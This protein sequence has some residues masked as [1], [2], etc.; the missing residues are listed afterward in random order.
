MRSHGGKKEKRIRREVIARDGLVCCYCDKKLLLQ[1]VT[2]EHIVPHSKKGQFNL[3]N[4][5]VSCAPCNNNRSSLDFFLYAKR[6]NWNKKKTLKYKRLYINGLKVKVLNLAKENFLITENAVPNDLIF[7]ACQLLKIKSIDLT[8]Y[9][10]CLSINFNEMNRR[11]AIIFNF[12][13]LIKIIAYDN[14]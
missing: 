14:A 10:N 5:T 11:T 8:K 2:M 1:E 9:E 3:T 4:L 6:F 12:E 13:N 7:L